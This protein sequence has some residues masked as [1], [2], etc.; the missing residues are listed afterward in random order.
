MTALPEGIVV[1][2]LQPEGSDESAH[3]HGAEP[4]WNE[5]WYCDFAD[6]HQGI[7]GYVRLGLTPNEGVAWLTALLCGPG[8]PTVAVIDFA[9]PL[10]GDPFALATDRYEF[11]HSVPMPLQTYRVGLSGR[12]EAFDDPAALLRG[13]CGR[14]V[15]VS[16]NLVWTTAGT[17][18][19]YRVTTRYE[20]PCT[21]A[22]TVIADGQRIDVDAVPGQRDHSWG[23]RDWWSMDWVWSA[24]HLDDGTHLHGLDVRLPAGPPIGIGYVQEPGAPLTELKAVTMREAFADSGLPLSP[25]LTLNPRAL[26]LAADIQGHAPL[27]LVAPDGRVSLFPRAWATVSTPDGRR[28]A[29][30]IEWNRHQET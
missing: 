29:G 14:A 18:Y 10:T 5:S 21:V 30:W 15:E 4:M 23:V 17:P 12:G 3:P 1:Q 28:G 27:R 6:P 22:G 26:D 19:R 25:T 9:A 13:E 11:T 20:I 8:R 7:G 24:W 16:M 2:P